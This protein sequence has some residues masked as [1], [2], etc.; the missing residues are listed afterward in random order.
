LEKKEKKKGGLLR[1]IPQSFR[2]AEK[3]TGKHAGASSSFCFVEKKKKK[4]DWGM[5]SASTCSCREGGG[6]AAPSY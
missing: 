4:N 5:K 6:V 2:R 1:F 3:K